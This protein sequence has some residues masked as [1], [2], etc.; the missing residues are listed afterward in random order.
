[1]HTKNSVPEIKM[2]N[3]MHLNKE[4]SDEKFWYLWSGVTK[5]KQLIHAGNIATAPQ[6]YPETLYLCN[7]KYNRT[8]EENIET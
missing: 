6:P 4:N 3:V 8:F 5:L 1:M 7:G 2:S